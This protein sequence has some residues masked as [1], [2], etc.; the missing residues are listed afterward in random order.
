MRLLKIFLLLVAL[1]LTA[2]AQSTTG[3][4]LEFSAHL[5]QGAAYDPYCPGSGVQAD[6]A[7][8]VRLEV[9][10]PT[11]NPVELTQV[12]GSFYDGNGQPL[13][14]D[15][16]ALTVPAGGRETVYLYY[17][18][19]AR[20]QV[21]SVLVTATYEAGGKPFQDQIAVTPAGEQR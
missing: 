5:L 6:P 3:G 15:R 7:T 8:R 2:L 21:T 14:T 19:L 18:N 13:F 9:S 12:L 17:N 11:S 4:P 16:Q 10:N 20:I 1:S